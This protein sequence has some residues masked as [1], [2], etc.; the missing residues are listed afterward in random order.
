[1][2]KYQ[3]NGHLP[4][5]HYIN[6]KTRAVADLLIWNFQF[7][8]I[9][10]VVA[11]MCKQQQALLKVKDI[12]YL[13]CHIYIYML[14]HICNTSYI[15]YIYNYSYNFIYVIYI[16]N[17]ALYL[18]GYVRKIFVMNYSFLRNFVK[19]LVNHCECKCSC[20]VINL[21]S[22]VIARWQTSRQVFYFSILH[23]FINGVTVIKWS[24][25]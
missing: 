14:F 4:P 18:V 15:N 5:T 1:M 16:R 10:P 9:T 19:N 25:L 23:T 11:A 24:S 2:V 13:I 8:Y 21:F 12:Q 22:M 6:S 17:K 7:H 20:I 3:K